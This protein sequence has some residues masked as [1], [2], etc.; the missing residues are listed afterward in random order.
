MFGTCY[1]VG[2]RKCFSLRNLKFC[3]IYIIMILAMLI[4]LQQSW[5]DK[6]LERIQNVIKRSQKMSIETKEEVIEDEPKA[7]EKTKNWLVIQ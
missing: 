3:D 7:E 1:I 6:F 4:N 2:M 5:S